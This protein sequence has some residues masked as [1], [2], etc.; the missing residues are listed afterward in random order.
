MPLEVYFNHFIK[1]I[2]TK[3]DKVEHLYS[4]IKFENNMEN[5][6]EENNMENILEEN[7]MARMRLNVVW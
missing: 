4:A 1:S 7:N 5:I 3:S 2:A 6:L